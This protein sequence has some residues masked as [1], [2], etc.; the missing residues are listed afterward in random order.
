MKL[1]EILT[2]TVMSVI[3]YSFCSGSMLLLN[4]LVLASIPMPSGVTL[5]QLIAAVILIFVLKFAGVIEVDNFESKKAK[6]YG[7]YVILFVLGVYANMRSLQ[8]SNV[9]T[10]IIFRAM[11]PIVVAF[12]EAAL[13]GRELPSRR[14]FLALSLIVA[15]AIGYVNADPEFET[16]GMSAYMW[17]SIYLVIICLEMTYGKKL[18]SDIK[19]TLGGSVLYTN[20]LSIV[21]MWSLFVITSESAAN[22]TGTVPVSMLDYIDPYSGIL[23]FISCLVGAG[24]GFA[25]WWCRSMVSAT[26]FTLIGV[27]NKVLTITVNLLIWEKHATPLGL[28]CLVVSLCGGTMYRQA[29]MRKTAANKF[30]PLQTIDTS[31]S[32]EELELNS[33]EEEV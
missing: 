11:T 6:L 9:E 8:V 10:V 4:K 29:P 14:S 31:I 17:P 30:V 7:V 2:P 16:A 23:L 22:S 28:M 20:A 13:L 5:V 12:M 27:I 26:S 1:K 25:G 15:G 18:V 32:D 19:L 24:I 33:A 3:A 21:P